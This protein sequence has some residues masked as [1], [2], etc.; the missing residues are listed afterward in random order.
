MKA[1]LQTS[2]GL[3][4]IEP[5]VIPVDSAFDISILAIAL[6]IMLTV[7]SI[8]AIRHYTSC[9]SKARRR[10]HQLYS[11]INGSADESH[12]FREISYQI[13]Q[14]LA[15]GTGQNGITGSTALPVELMHYHQRWQDFTRSLSSARYST[16]CCH[17]PSL[18]GM[19]KESFFWLKHWP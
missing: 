13:A 19:F 1:P 7:C 8:F 17:R 12:N 3:L 15:S 16:K 11:S 10:L 6:V 4:D 14:I 5:P 2:S 18:D 9:R